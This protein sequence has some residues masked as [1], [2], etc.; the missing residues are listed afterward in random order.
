MGIL[1]TFNKL[2]SAIV[3]TKTADIDVSL[4]KAIKDITSFKSQSGRLGYIELLKSLISKQGNDVVNTS[5]FVQSNSG[6]QTPA[7]YGQARRLGRYKTYESIVSH[8][9]YCFRALTVFTENILS[10]DD[11]TKKTLDIKP[12]SYIENQTNTESKTKLVKEVI[13]KVQLEKNLDLIVK[14]TLL[15]GDFFVEIGTVR[16]ALTGNAYLAESYVEGDNTNYVKSFMFE[17]DEQKLKVSLDYSSFVEAE[18]REKENVEDNNIDPDD[19]KLMFH[20][21]KNI[22]K[23]QT[24]L[25]PVCF[26]YLVFPRVMFNRQCQLADQAVNDMCLRI[27]KDLENK[28]PQT[29]ELQKNEDLIKIIKS[30]INGS[31]FGIGKQ[32]NI[33]YVPADKIEH[34]KVP[35]I[36]YYPYGESIFDSVVFQ[37]KVLVS[38]ETALTIQRLARST[39]KRKI[40]IEVGLPRDAKKMVESIKEKFRKRKISLDSFG[41]V[42]TIPSMI[43]TFED[44]YIP[45]KDGKPFVDIDTFTGGNVDI[46]SKV[47]E[48]KF[49]R[50]SLIAALGVPPA[51]LSLEEN[52]STKAT[53]SDENILFARAVIGHQKYLTE[54]TVELIQKLFQLINPEESL[55]ILDNITIT[56][57]T[58]KSLQFELLSKRINDTVTLIESLERIGVPQEYSKKKYL[59]DIDWDEVENFQI[60]TDIEKKLGTEPKEA[61]DEFGG[62][63]GGMGG[64]PPGI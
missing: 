6:A 8:I 16:T 59:E 27:L 17:N 45:Q 2:K 38:L 3:G 43:T 31:D 24:D 50:D 63:G 21:P 30:M 34:F 12:N 4:D 55:T 37:S 51:F 28:I 40:A 56:F 42:D 14:N 46:R 41:T 61:E 54:Q 49:M 44:I 7:M 25:F 23:L 58:P 29:K 32:I 10:P 57:P 47:D 15:F 11:I 20:E 5:S 53:L 19:I 64:V 36:K 39:E 52:V 1:S 62:M 48:L 22:V 13:K 26:G 9:S 33:R 60:G 35:S 18:N